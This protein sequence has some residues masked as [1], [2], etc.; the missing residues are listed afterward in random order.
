MKLGA[1]FYV[2]FWLDRMICVWLAKVSKNTVLQGKQIFLAEDEFSI[3]KYQEAVK[4]NS[5]PNN[6]Q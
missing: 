6:F 3:R 2:N 4:Q 1:K 5:N